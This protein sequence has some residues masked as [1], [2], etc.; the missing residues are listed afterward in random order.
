MSDFGEEIINRLPRHSSL[1]NKNHPMRKIIDGTIGEWLQNQEDTDWFSQFFLTE[2]TGKYLD[3][4]GQ[5]FGLLRKLDESDED[6]RARIIYESLG[7]LTS[8]FLI[9]VY[10]VKL[11]SYI[12]DFNLEENTLVSD[13]HYIS[14]Q[15]YLAD[16][17]D[18]VKNILN[19][20]FVLGSEVTWL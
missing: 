9:N 2:A 6:Y 20:K 3:L 8:D 15:G 17:D 11:Y 18:T 4:H 12:P 19:R 13:N 5:T 16:A 10:D 7:H 14:G 1:H